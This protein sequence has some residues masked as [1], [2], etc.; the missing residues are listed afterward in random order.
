MQDIFNSS[1]WLSSPIAYWTIQYEYRRSSADMEYRFYWKVWIGANSWFN[2]ALTLRLFL[3]GKQNDVTVKGKTTSKGWSYEGTT[4]WY[5]VANKASGTVPFYAQLFDVSANELKVTSASYSLSVSPSK[6]TLNSAPDFTDENN[7]TITY[8]NPSG[9]QV[10]SLQVRISFDRNGSNNDS[11]NFIVTRNLPKTN[12]SYQIKLEESERIAL[13]KAM[14]TVTSKTI[15]F[16]VRT[17]V[18]NE[19]FWSTLDRT[20]RI[21]NANPSF[22]ADQISYT[23]ANKIL[24][25]V[26]GNQADNQKIVQNK[27]SL[28]VTFGAASG[29]KEASI[30]QYILT[31]NGVTKTASASGTVSFGVVNL[32]QNATLSLTV[33]DSR[34]NTTTVTKSITILP[35]SVPNITANI[36]RK[37]NYEDET[38]LSVVASIS[39]VDGKNSIKSIT[40]QYKENGGSYGSAVSISNNTEYEFSLSKN[41]AYTFKI[42]VTDT[43][44]SSTKEISLSKGKFPLF[45]DTEKNAV[46]VNEFPEEGEALRV[47]GGVARFD[48]GIVLVSASKRFLLSVNDNG[49]LS[50][51]EI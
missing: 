3:N 37:N 10:S 11:N 38:H 40:Y 25:T 5:K 20:F 15:V 8:S 45:I 41:K 16:Y 49:T 4:G 18:G 35:Y 42:S 47:G 33:K 17:Q 44:G 30:S 14:S 21:E 51:T 43:F 13:R 19:V 1:Q 6:A 39:S 46:G 7:P 24:S 28:S 34:G 36:S 32:S 29:I 23:D 31:L 27:S 50:I 12:S 2:D 22:R 26:T 48:G 9:D